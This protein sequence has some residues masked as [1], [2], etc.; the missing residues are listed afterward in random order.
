MII[1][2]TGATHTG[3]TIFAQ[4]LL[5][6]YQYPYLSI[7][8]L[9]M[10]LIRSGYCSL[11]P[12]SDYTAL[13]KYLWPVVR[14]IIKTAIE[15]CQ[16]LII[17]GC[18]IPFTYQSDFSQNYLKEIQYLCIILSE[19]YIQNHY[20]NILK[21]ACRIEKR[22][23]VNSISKKMLIEENIFNLGK[24]KEYDL[25]YVLIDDYYKITWEPHFE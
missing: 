2:I 13:T 9:K 10:G 19:H 21:H 16:N 25:E 4:E 6:K 17:E 24:C 7:D 20:D 15:N 11:T 12:E 18:Y 22:I 3:K 14:E 23:K 1:I 5:E 8:H